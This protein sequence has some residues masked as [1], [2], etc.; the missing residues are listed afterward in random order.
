MNLI[1]CDYL[2]VKWLS[3]PWCSTTL[4]R[5][6]NKP[7]DTNASA[8]NKH[9]VN[10]K[11]HNRTVKL[12]WEITDGTVKPAWMKFFRKK[13][14]EEAPIA[15]P[16]TTH[17]HLLKYTCREKLLLI[18]KAN[19]AKNLLISHLKNLQTWLDNILNNLKLDS[20]LSPLS[21]HDARTKNC[22]SSSKE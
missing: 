15:A 6:S 4:R 8:P 2:T 9:H 12:I 18:W 1:L 11:L 3:P 14:D 21:F 7:Q 17:L 16:T 19:H 22:R 13:F 10:S 5:A 20:S